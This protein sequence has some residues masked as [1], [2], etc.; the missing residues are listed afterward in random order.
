M[1]RARLGGGSEHACVR[2]TVSAAETGGRTRIPG[3]QRD[4]LQVIAFGAGL[5]GEAWG[6]GDLIFGVGVGGFQQK[7]HRGNAGAATAALIARRHLRESRPA[8]NAVAWCGRGMAAMEKRIVQGIV[9]ELGELLG[10]RLHVAI[11]HDCGRGTQIGAKHERIAGGGVD[12][13]RS[14]GTAFRRVA[15]TVVGRVMGD[16]KDEFA[17]LPGQL[18]ED[19]L[20]QKFHIDDGEGGSLLRRG[21][22]IA[23]AQRHVDLEGL[24]FRLAQQCMPAR[25]AGEC[26]PQQGVGILGVVARGECEPGEDG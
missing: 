26:G 21:E 24:H 22:D 23:V 6:C 16:G 19:C 25:F 7:V 10:D 17:L 14:P 9:D 3:Q 1:C 15:V 12:A 20:L 13:V 11:V 5:G 18:L 4:V 2:E 8:G